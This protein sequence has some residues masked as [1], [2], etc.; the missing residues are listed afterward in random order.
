MKLY[1]NSLLPFFGSPSFYLHEFISGD[2]IAFNAKCIYAYITLHTLIMYSCS[3]IG[4]G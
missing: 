2:K 3:C 4:E 1:R